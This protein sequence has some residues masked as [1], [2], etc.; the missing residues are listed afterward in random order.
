LIKALLTGIAIVGPL[1]GLALWWFW[2]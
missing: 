1:F 2:G